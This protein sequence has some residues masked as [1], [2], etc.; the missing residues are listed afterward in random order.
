MLTAN[1]FEYLFNLVAG[2]GANIDEISDDFFSVD[3]DESVIE[4]PAL[5]NLVVAYSDHGAA[6]DVMYVKD[7]RG[8]FKNKNPSKVVV[9]VEACSVSRMDCEIRRNAFHHQI[10]APYVPGCDMVGTVVQVGSKAIRAYDYRVGDRVCALGLKLGGNARYTVV[11]GSQLIQVPKALDAAEV[12]CLI[13]TYVTAFQCL[14]RAGG[15]SIQRGDKILVLGGGSCVGQAIAQLAQVAGADEIYVTGG[16][17]E[18]SKK[19]LE[20]LGAKPVGRKPCE[21]L[22]V[23]EGEMDVVIDIVSDGDDD[24][25]YAALNEDG[26]LV[27]LG[28]MSKPEEGYLSRFFSNARERSDEGEIYD[29]FEYK[30]KYPQKFE[31]DLERLFIMLEYGEI[32]PKISK[33]IPL[34]E[35]TNAHK[36]IDEG[37]VGGTVVCMPFTSEITFPKEKIPRR[38]I[39]LFEQKRPEQEQRIDGNRVDQG[40]DAGPDPEPKEMGPQIKWESREGQSTLREDSIPDYTRKKTKIDIVRRTFQKKKRGGS[41]QGNASARLDGKTKEQQQDAAA[42]IEAEA[43]KLVAEMLRAEEAA[44][45]AETQAT[46]AQIAAS[47]AELVAN[48]E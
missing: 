10:E 38:R 6:T 3:D 45:R 30:R 15:T 5:E 46:E 35:V 29:L 31:K 14:H 41:K 32:A 11:D 2:D 43:N 25:C 1:S 19:I 20:S 40:L 37:S 47:K 21:W 18:H 27:V 28:D 17:K 36:E 12:A 16:E 48:A 39:E 42:T 26:K 22:P 8:K 7:I 44:R 4:Y 9:K 13:R 23:V 34:N 24:S 33:C